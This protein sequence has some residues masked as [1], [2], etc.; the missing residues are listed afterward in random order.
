MGHVQDAQQSVNQRQP[1]CH[2]GVHAALYQPLNEQFQV[3]HKKI[4]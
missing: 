4:P 2:N 3:K 1:N